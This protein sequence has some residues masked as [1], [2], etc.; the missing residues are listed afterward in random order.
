MQLFCDAN[1][2]K[3]NYLAVKIINL[4][5]KGLEI[6]GKYNRNIETKATLYLFPGTIPLAAVFVAI[7]TLLKALAHAHN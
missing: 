3:H 7:G 4:R 6:G 2:K 1:R 5:R